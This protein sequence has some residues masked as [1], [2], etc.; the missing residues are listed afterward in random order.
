MKKHIFTAAIALTFAAAAHAAAPCD[1]T[2]DE[3][4]PLPLFYSARKGNTAN[5]RCLLDAGADVNDADKDGWTALM[6]AAVQGHTTPCARSL[7]RVQTS[8]PPMHKAG[9]R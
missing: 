1:T 9:R 7:T 2:T 6:Y 4:A 3:K 5:V 8:T